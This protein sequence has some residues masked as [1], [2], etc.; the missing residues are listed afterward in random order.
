MT[1]CDGCDGI[2]GIGCGIENIVTIVTT[3]T[4]DDGKDG[5]IDRIEK[6]ADFREIILCTFEISLGGNG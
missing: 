6:C 4:E 1:I 3:V 2:L 5:L